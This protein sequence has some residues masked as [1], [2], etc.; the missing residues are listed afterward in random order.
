MIGGGQQINLHP[1]SLYLDVLYQRSSIDYLGAVRELYVNNE[2]IQG[3]SGM[4]CVEYLT[5][6]SKINLRLHSQ[7][8]IHLKG[9]YDQGSV[10]KEKGTLLHQAEFL[11]LIPAGKYGCKGGRNLIHKIVPDSRVRV[12]PEY[13]TFGQ[14]SHK[15]CGN[16]VIGR[17]YSVGIAHKYLPL[18]RSL[19]LTPRS[20]KKLYPEFF[21][22]F[23]YILADRRLADAQHP[24]SLRETAGRIHGL[25]N[26]DP[27]IFHNG[28]HQYDSTKLQELQFICK[29]RS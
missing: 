1:V 20:C 22:Q 6:V 4:Q 13:C 10:Y 8:N 15:G 3:A 11:F 2:G 21:L 19:H 17:R 12:Y 25:E 26:L 27:E 29:S 28:W 5:V 7:W 24:C 23:G 16:G 18:A 14:R 9:F